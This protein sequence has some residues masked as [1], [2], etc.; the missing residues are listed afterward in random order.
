MWEQ[1]E[2]VIGAYDGVRMR[3]NHEIDMKTL[4]TLSDAGFNM[5]VQSDYWYSS[6]N[7]YNGYRS[8]NPN[9]VSIKYILELLA[10]FNKK[11]EKNKIR[12]IVLDWD[13]GVDKIPKNAPYTEH[14]FEKYL[15]L[16]P[17]LRDVLYG[18][19][20]L[21]E[22]GLSRLKECIPA[23]RSLREIDKEKMVYVNLGDTGS[24]FRETVRLLAQNSSV[25]S[26]D[27]YHFVTTSK[28]P[29]NKITDR[30]Y[31]YAQIVAEETRSANIP[32]WG[33]P[34]SVEHARKNVYSGK[35][36]WGHML[37][38]RE[39]R[40]PKLELGR[41]RFSAHA[42]LIYGA[43]GLVWYSYDMS[44]H[45]IVN[46]GKI[47]EFIDPNIPYSFYEACLDYYGNPTIIYDYV[48][49]VNKKVLSMA[50]ILMDLRWICT[51]HSLYFNNDA[52]IPSD[53]L[54][55][56][57]SSV[58]EDIEVAV[59]IFEGKDKNKYLIVMNKNLKN[60]KTITLELRNIK[61]ASWFNTKTKK[62]QSMKI[63]DNRISID[64]ENA[65]IEVIKLVEEQAEA[66]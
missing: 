65:D 16:P 57:V 2:F 14:R 5:M 51:V 44:N 21:D 60:D 55:V 66:Q 4:K 9:A 28:K 13:I 19:S 54:P 35:I 39:N 11:Y 56:V 25:V 26:F 1:K 22:P 10:D 59:G 61:K 63:T 23:I 12:F 7:F 37:Y 8:Y 17:E 32:W 64:V 45:P 36:I 50:Q 40:N 24:D 6:R 52:E 41:I 43:K 53:K 62:W 30:Y 38:D 48:K 27:K 47:E 58:T 20:L 42:A 46:P 29:S 18:Y 33:V 15:E 3:G 34:L 49:Q 31:L